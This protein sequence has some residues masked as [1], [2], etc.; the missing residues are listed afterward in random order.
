MDHVIVLNEDHLRRILSK[1]ASYYNEVRTHLSL[2]KDAPLHAPDRAVRRHYRAADPWWA[3]PSIRTNLRFSEATTA[4]FAY[5]CQSFHP[6]CDDLA[7]VIIPR[8]SCW[9]AIV[10]CRSRNHQHQSPP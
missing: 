5:E 9:P 10:H 7:A 3:T 6:I 4:L 2:G 1:Y 8:E